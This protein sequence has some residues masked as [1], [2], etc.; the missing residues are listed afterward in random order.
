VTLLVMTIGLPTVFIIGGFTYKKIKNVVLPVVLNFHLP[1]FLF[2]FKLDF[3]TATVSGVV[4]QINA[5]CWFP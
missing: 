4:S 2:F 5:I 3:I 1:T